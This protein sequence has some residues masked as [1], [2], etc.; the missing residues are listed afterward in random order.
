[1]PRELHEILDPYLQRLERGLD[2]RVP[3]E[4]VAGRR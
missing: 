1:M 3:S 2:P 4:T